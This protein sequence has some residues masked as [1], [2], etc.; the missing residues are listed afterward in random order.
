MEPNVRACVAFVAGRMIS[1]PNAQS[2]YDCS[3]SRYI[4]Y[5]GSVEAL[6]VR[7]FDLNQGCFF[8]G[9][10][11][12]GSFFLYHHGNGHRVNLTIQEDRFSGVDQRSLMHFHGTVKEH[13]VQLFDQGAN[14]I[15]EYVV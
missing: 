1:Q 11:G 15:F 7:I 6:D 9:T 12:G 4:C 5:A 2:L 8:S 3:R 13:F 10:G 14:G